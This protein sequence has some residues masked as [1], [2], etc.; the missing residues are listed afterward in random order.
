MGQK[1]YIIDTNAPLEDPHSQVKPHNGNER[2]ALI[3][4]HALLELNKI[5]KGPK[6]RHIVARVMVCRF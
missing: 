6:I 3:P 4:Y 2:S 5:K 1:N